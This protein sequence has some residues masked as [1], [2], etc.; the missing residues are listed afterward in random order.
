MQFNKFANSLCLNAFEDFYKQF[1]GEQ[2]TINSGSVIYFKLNED[3]WVKLIKALS[4]Y[5]LPEISQ[6]Y[7]YYV[8]ADSQ[9]TRDFMTNSP[10][11][12]VF[13]FNYAKQVQV[14]GRKYYDALK[15]VAARTV[16]YFYI[17][18]TN[19]SSDEFWGILK[20]AK[21]VKYVG[22]GLC[23]IPF[24]YETDFREGMEN[25]NIEDI[26]LHSS[27]GATYSNWAENPIRFENFIASISKCAPL[28]NS[29]NRLEI[30]YCDITR[31]K[32]QGVLNKYKLDGVELQG[33]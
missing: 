20:A 21:H 15:A 32:A 14:E 24:D 17:C 28:V 13:Y 19:L 26:D 9:E 33:V 30:E 12:N 10:A 29:L 5:S 6:S 27:G 23:S 2:I 18:N 1:I 31:E 11:Q 7:L 25:C 3:K 16:E 8:P 4:N 22:F